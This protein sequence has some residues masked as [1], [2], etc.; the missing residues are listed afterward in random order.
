MDIFL[1]HYFLTSEQTCMIVNAG[2]D[3]NWGKLTPYTIPSGQLFKNHCP[4]L[5]LFVVFF[6]STVVKN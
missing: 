2:S 4:P 5:L 1:K 3:G 6:T